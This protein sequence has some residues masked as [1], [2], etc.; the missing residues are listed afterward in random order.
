MI[1]TKDKITELFRLPCG[2]LDVSA[3]AICR[4][5]LKDS[6]DKLL[7]RLTKEIHPVESLDVSVEEKNSNQ[8]E[9]LIAEG[10]L[11]AEVK[12]AVKQYEEQ[13]QGNS[14]LLQD[15]S[16]TINRW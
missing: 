8:K 15:I 12:M 6:M 2:A 14:K 5:S 7:D 13:L 3:N 16:G 9:R 1:K 10:R 4:R 11:K